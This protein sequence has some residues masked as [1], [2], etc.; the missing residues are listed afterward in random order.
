M[1]DD[2]SVPSLIAGLLQHTLERTQLSHNRLA[3]E[4]DM[5]L[6]RFQALLETEGDPISEAEYAQLA[7]I[8]NRFCLKSIN[9]IATLL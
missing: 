6:E 9:S 7:K 8:I 1:T 5:D 4:L 2:I 3:T